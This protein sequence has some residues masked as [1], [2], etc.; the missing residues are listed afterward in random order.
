MRYLMALALGLTMTLVS[1]T[2]WA[3][4]CR[5]FND[6]GYSFSVESGNVSNQRV[7]SHTRTS[8]SSGKIKAVDED[9][10]KSVGGSCQD[11]DEIKIVEDDGVLMIVHE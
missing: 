4:S 7:G 9:A 6:T 5:I 1:G 3:G 10:G 11:G 8:I 2:A